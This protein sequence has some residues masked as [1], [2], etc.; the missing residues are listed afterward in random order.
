MAKI[1][2]EE[3]K[4]LLISTDFKEESYQELPIQTVIILKNSAAVM[5]T[6]TQG[7]EKDKAALFFEKRESFFLHLILRRIQK[8]ETLYCT[9]SKATNLP[10]VFCDPESANDQVWFFS[11]EHFAQKQVM[12]SRQE[13]IE[14]VLV[15][16]ENKQ[17]LNFFTSLF[18]MGVNAFVL[19]KGANAVEIEL[20]QLVRRPD[21]SKV[22]EAKRPLE[23][24]ELTLTGM[25]FA[26]ERNKPEEERDKQALHDFEEEMIV[27]L[28]RNRVIVPVQM[29]EEPQEKV[30][31]K[32]LKIPFLKLQNGDIYLPLC[33]DMAEFQRFNQKKQLKA[34]IVESSKLGSMMGEN[35][36]GVMLNPVT[37]RLLIPKKRVL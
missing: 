13:H 26:Q 32:D 18:T 28:K 5:K 35:I 15:K 22:P 33:G 20:N 24:Q 16:L 1:N 4:K 27:N 8:L 25:Y 21:L 2:E 9:F 6:K 19:D 7:E 11:D 36:K 10:Y 37:L 12:V 34:I 30:E 17:F 14:L 29:P 31:A 3:L 23:N